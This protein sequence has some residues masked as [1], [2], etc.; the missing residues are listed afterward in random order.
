M[1]EDRFEYP[2]EFVK[3]NILGCLEASKACCTV[4]GKRHLFHV[5]FEARSVSV[6]EQMLTQDNTPLDF[7]L[8]AKYEHCPEVSWYLHLQNEASKRQELPT[9][10]ADP[11]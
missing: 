11:A 3:Q 8:E 5:T 10:E 2:I 4:P 6:C 7:F 1:S 9:Q